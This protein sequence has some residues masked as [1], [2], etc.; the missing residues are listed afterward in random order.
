M[1]A[2][3]ERHTSISFQFVRWRMGEKIKGLGAFMKEHEYLWLEPIIA[4][5]ILVAALSRPV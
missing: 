1:R 2:S 3:H 4:V 5:L